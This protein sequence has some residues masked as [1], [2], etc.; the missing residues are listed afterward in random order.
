MGTINVHEWINVTTKTTGCVF[1]RYQKV[2][3]NPFF[4]ELPFVRTK[5]VPRFSVADFAVVVLLG[6]V[7]LGVVDLVVG[8]QAV[9]PSVQVCS[10]LASSAPHSPRQD[11]PFAQ[12]VSSPSSLRAHLGHSKSE[13]GPASVNKSVNASMHIHKR[14]VNKCMR[15]WVIDW[16]HRMKWI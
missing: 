8:E 16:L 14:V 13:S 4:S 6:V 15:V 7:G 1:L 9:M 2:M 3:L 12:Q 10:T 5:M 11:P